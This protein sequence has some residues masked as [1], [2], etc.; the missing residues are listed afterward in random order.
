MFTYVD[1]L[2][3]KIITSQTCRLFSKKTGRKYLGILQN[4]LVQKYINNTTSLKKRAAIDPQKSIISPDWRSVGLETSKSIDTECK[5]KNTLL[6]EVG[7]VF[8]CT[9]NNSL[10]SKPQKRI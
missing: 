7:L 5:E 3:E 8:T 1:S 10:T 6:F 9:Y 2:D 4:R